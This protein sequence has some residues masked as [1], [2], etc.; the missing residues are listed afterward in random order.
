MSDAAIVFV[1]SNTTGTGRLLCRVA[2]ARGLRPV[3]LTRAP[4]RYPYL[5]T[6]G[7]E[8][9]LVD[10]S[11]REAVHAACS[12]VAGSI[13]GV[14]SSSEYYVS[15]AARIAA[16]LGLPAP[17]S[18]AVE[19]ARDKELQRELLARAEVPVPG[20]RLAT[21][22]EAALHMANEL[23]FPVVIKPVSGSGSVGVRLCRGDTE[24]V[25]AAKNLLSSAVNERGLPVNPRILV[26]QY[27]CGSEFSVEVFD[28]EV[29]GVTAKHL[30]THPFFVEIGHDFPARLSEKRVAVITDCA[31]RAVC[32]L[33]LTWG[34]V[35][36]ELR[37]GESGPV[38]IEVNPRL[39]GGMIPELVR[40]AYGVDLL[41]CV[42]ARVSG[43]L[44]QLNRKQ[45]EH[46]AIRFLLAPGD[47][48]ILDVEGLDSA[49]AVQSVRSVVTTA[50]PGDRIT[51][52]RS[53]KDRIGSIIAAHPHPAVA[54][55]QAEAALA[56]ITV[57]MADQ[58]ECQ[59]NS[60]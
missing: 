28:G 7:I 25:T 44:A 49:R 3:M 26:E 37:L 9:H 30:G 2:R 31:R 55:R 45:A 18:A 24:V 16:D 42:I 51:L 46:A 35:H 38:I 41:D 29:V 1:E 13:A 21:T 59:E 27:I 4:S 34:A 58:V 19:R 10:T 6:D 33:D 17:N 36:V 14:T 57:R 40:L 22:P 47:G 5:E 15:L 20:F 32:A 39:A 12:S 56:C 8:T 50:K 43:G 23:G 11:D 54:I 60:A 48:K 53:F 52:N